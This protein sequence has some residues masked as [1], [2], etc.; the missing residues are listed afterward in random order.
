VDFYLVRHG[1][2][3]SETI[4]PQRPLSRVG[5]RDVEHLAQSAMARE[6]RPSAILHSGI[7]RARQTA[8]VLAQFLSPPAGVRVSAG[9]APE[10]DPMIAKGELETAERS[11]MLVGHLPHL[12]R[13]VALLT[14]GDPEAQG[15]DLMLATMVCCSLYRG[16]WRI[17]WIIRPD[18]G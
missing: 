13:L 9:L 15:I 18:A 1:E 17:L 10:D 8:E 14:R 12:S 3:V 7:L 6:V 11:L 4:D 2:A 5:Y 16:N